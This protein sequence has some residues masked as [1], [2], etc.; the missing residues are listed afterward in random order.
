MRTRY[1]LNRLWK[2]CWT[3]TRVGRGTWRIAKCYLRREAIAAPWRFV[4]GSATERR[5]A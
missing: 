5:F 3:C 4:R 2:I 1:Y